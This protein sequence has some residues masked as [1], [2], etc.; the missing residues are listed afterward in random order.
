MNKSLKRSDQYSSKHWS[1]IALISLVEIAS[2]GVVG[3][4]Y[5]LRETEGAFRA[6]PLRAILTVG[7]FVEEVMAH[8][9]LDANWDAWDLG[10]RA[11]PSDAIPD[12]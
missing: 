8:R 7:L 2:D 3:L 10:C 9:F 11:F 1:R 5:G 4:I 12:A 6:V